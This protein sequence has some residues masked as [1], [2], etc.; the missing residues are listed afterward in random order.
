[1]AVYGILFWG[2]CIY[3][4]NKTEA[5]EFGGTVANSKFIATEPAVSLTHEDWISLIILLNDASSLEAF[6]YYLIV[7]EREPGRHRAPRE[8]SR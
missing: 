6:Q 7:P 8:L 5:I 2:Q 4:M 3:A 1:V